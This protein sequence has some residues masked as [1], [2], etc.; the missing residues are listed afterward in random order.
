MG[1]SVYSLAI[2]G[3]VKR[4]SLVATEKKYAGLRENK[5]Y[6]YLGTSLYG[7]ILVHD[8]CFSF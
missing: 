6:V 7:Q 2:W 4:R 5:Y 8:I 1:A 3:V